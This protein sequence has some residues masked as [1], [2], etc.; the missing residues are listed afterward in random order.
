M[1]NT[2]KHEDSDD[3]D[4]YSVKSFFSENKDIPK[5]LCQM[6]K[7]MNIPKI[8]FQHQLTHTPAHP[9]M[10]AQINDSSTNPTMLITGCSQVLHA[11]NGFGPIP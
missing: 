9:V 1:F 8:K 3:Y 7:R 4:Q 2:G 6:L 10:Q 11:N 5:I